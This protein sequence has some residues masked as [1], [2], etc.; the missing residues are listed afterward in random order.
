MPSLLDFEWSKAYAIQAISDLNAYSVLA[1]GS[2]DQCH[3]LHYLQMASEK[4]CKAYLCLSNGHNHVK[5]KHNYVALHLP[6]IARR[7]LAESG[8]RRSQIQNIKTLSREIEV[9]APAVHKGFSREDNCE[10]PWADTSGKVIVPCKFSFPG[11]S[12]S[13]RRIN[14]LL[15]VLRTA[16]EA[17]AA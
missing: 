3:L 9:L 4:V 14:L 6:L 1:Q 11:I 10:Y 17:Y 2:A 16:A 7:F 5:K 15:R 12:V 8:G 13:D